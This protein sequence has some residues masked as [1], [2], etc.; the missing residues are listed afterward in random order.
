M[1]C[2]NNFF[3]CFPNFLGNRIPYYSHDRTMAKSIPDCLI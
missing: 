3:I 1:S 2:K